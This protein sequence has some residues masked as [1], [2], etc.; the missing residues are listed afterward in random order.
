[1]QET[2][3]TLLKILLIF[4]LG[5]SGSVTAS[6]E[7]M[8]LR[9]RACA[10]CHEQSN[11]AN[12]DKNYAPSI[13][14]K[15][16]EYLYQQLL[17]F[18][19]GRRLNTVMNQMLAYLSPE[20]L[21]EIASYYAQQDPSSS[22]PEI[23]QQSDDQAARG[24]FLVQQGETGQPACATCHGGDLRGNDIA[25]PGLRGLSASYITAQ[26]GAWQ[27]STRHA[28]TPDCMAEV[29]KSLSG[30][31]IDAVA[32]WIATASDALLTAEAPLDPL[33]IECGAVQ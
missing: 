12:F 1:M 29:A 11:T 31:D 25:I 23:K 16:V 30:A 5:Y 18:Q 15:P 27:T 33:P 22:A 26:L 13:N 21:H 6:D 19:E 4:W 9:L 14:G 3:K 7:D 10:G 17:N 20:Y 32:H 8:N 24:R 28:R 2:Q